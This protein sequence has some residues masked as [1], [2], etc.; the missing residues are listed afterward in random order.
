MFCNIVDMPITRTKLAREVILGGRYLT[1]KNILLEPV[2]GSRGKPLGGRTHAHEDPNEAPANISFFRVVDGVVDKSKMYPIMP[3]Y[4][5]T[6]AYETPTVYTICEDAGCNLVETINYL[7]VCLK[8]RNLF[9]IYR[10]GY[11]GF[12]DDPKLE[13]LVEY[14]EKWPVDRTGCPF[15]VSVKKLKDAGKLALIPKII[16]TLSSDTR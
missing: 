14:M 1:K 10:K 12:L 15:R 13:W 16:E 5:L 11:I 3:G 4:E 2:P 8:G 7:R 6:V 9:R